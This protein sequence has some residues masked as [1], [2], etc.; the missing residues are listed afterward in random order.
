MFFLSWS[1]ENADTMK[2]KVDAIMY[3]DVSIMTKRC[4]VLVNNCTEKW[5]MSLYLP[6]EGVN[7]L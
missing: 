4:D 5:P 7:I 3:G 2:Y 1:Y 6:R